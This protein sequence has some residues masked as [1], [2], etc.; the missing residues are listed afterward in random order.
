MFEKFVTVFDGKAAIG[1]KNL[2]SYSLS[3]TME[4]GQ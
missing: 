2:C 4:C 3:D 1:V